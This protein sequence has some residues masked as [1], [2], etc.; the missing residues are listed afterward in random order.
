MIYTYVMMYRRTDVD[1]WTKRRLAEPFLCD[2]H[3]FGIM[4]ITTSPWY[5]HST[6]IPYHT[7]W[8]LFCIASTFHGFL[9]IFAEPILAGQLQQTT[10]QQLFAGKLQR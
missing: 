7:C 5:H 1:G 6:T 4:N 10:L 3:T 9:N 2:I 8:L